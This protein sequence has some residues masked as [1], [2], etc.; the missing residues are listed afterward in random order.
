M[1]PEARADDNRCPECGMSGVRESV[2]ADAEQT[3][4]IYTCRNDDG[5][6]VAQYTITQESVEKEVDKRLSEVEV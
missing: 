1:T 5:C 2:D 4:I 6:E 3:E